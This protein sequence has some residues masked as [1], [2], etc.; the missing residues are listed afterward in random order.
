MD[1]A[2][3]PKSIKKDLLQREI[4]F[5]EKYLGRYPHD[6]LLIDYDSYKRNPVYG[7]EK[8]PD[9]LNPFSDVF[10]WD[11]K[12]FKILSKKIIEN[13]IITDKNKD[14]WLTEGIQI[15]LMMEYVNTY[16]PE[17]KLFG[18]LSK[19]WGL[20][21]FNVTQLDFNEK[22]PFVYQ[23]TARKNLDQSLTTQIDS[24]SNFNR[25]LV[26]SYKSG[27]GMRYL[28]QFLGDSIFKSS[29]KQFVVDNRLKTNIVANFEKEIAKNT[30]K[31]IKWFFGD[32]LHSK[33]KID[34]TLEKVKRD[35]DSIYITVKKQA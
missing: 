10:K 23:F 5:I 31:D 33:K 7:L 15:Y 2:S 28:E 26:N 20:R 19:I 3:I 11:V 4:D 35:K 13:T 16:Y 6:E 12:V 14:Y 30:D 22:Y 17:A 24:L 29:L 9:F 21:T 32:Y 18:N 25:M 8:I 1:E 34:Y 27:L